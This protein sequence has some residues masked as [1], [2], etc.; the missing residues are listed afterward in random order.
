MT[1]C[2]GTLN[3]NALGQF[4]AWFQTRNIAVINS[5]ALCWGLLTEKGPPPWHPASD[6]IKE[7]CLAATTYCSVSFYTF[8][9]SKIVSFSLRI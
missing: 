6:E 9:N 2:K 7:A 5:G 1:Y 4:T 3:N 8:V